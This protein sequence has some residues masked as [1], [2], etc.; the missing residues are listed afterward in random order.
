VVVSKQVAKEIR[1]ETGSENDIGFV[2]R[3]AKTPQFPNR[4]T[5]DGGVA[6]S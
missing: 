2:Q 5:S 1:F 4:G 6:V 3:D